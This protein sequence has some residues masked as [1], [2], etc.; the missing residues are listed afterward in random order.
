[1][2]IL[3]RTMTVTALIFWGLLLMSWMGSRIAPAQDGGCEA[4]AAADCGCEICGCQAC[5]PQQPCQACVK[6]GCRLRQRQSKAS[7]G[8][9][10]HSRK[11]PQCQGDVCVLEVNEAEVEKTCF[12]IEQKV[13]CIPEVRL[14]WKKG[15]PPT[16]SR[17]RV[18]NQLKTHK[19]KCP[20][21]EYKWN[22]QEP[23][24]CDEPIAAV[25][26]E[27]ELSPAGE[28]DQS[29]TPQAETPTVPAF[30]PES[31]E[32]P[33]PARPPFEALAPQ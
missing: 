24:F 12:Q 28:N 8:C 19:Y 2:N 18:V 26:Y 7:C 13:V 9:K 27:I 16:V 30:E 17:S 21:C 5:Q 31:L 10:K 33:F 20:S 3:H 4:V 23:V 11:C 15:C 14:P 32:E 1:M 25:P 22:V 6:H 29:A